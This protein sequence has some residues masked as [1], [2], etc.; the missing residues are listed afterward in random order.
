MGYFCY[1]RSMNLNKN[2][3]KGIVLLI[4]IFSIFSLI[5][6][7]KNQEIKKPEVLKMGGV[8]LNI[9][10]ADTDPERVQGLSGR[11]GLEDNEGLLFVFGREDYYGIWMKD[12]NFPIDIVWF[13]KNK[14]VTHMENVV[15]PDT[16]PKVFSSAIP[17]LYV[18]EIP[19]GFL[20]KN[21]I[22]IGDSVAF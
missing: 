21:N 2:H 15:R 7:A 3:K 6:L 9:E 12:M 18:L 20:V 16:Y 11:D 22:K 8:T 19:A 5:F 4:I 10:V 14:N 13:D 17:S 1:D